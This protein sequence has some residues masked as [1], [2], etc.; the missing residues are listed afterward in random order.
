MEGQKDK[1]QGP[2]LQIL[3]ITLFDLAWS[4]TATAESGSITQTPLLQVSS[5]Q[6][7]VFISISSH[8]ASTSVPM[9]QCGFSRE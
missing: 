9:L 5:R 6:Q 4:T 8:S 1:G 7:P 3:I 2:P